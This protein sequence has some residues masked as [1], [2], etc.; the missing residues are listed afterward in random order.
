MGKMASGRIG[1]RGWK[2]VRNGKK[3][4]KVWRGGEVDQTKVSLELNS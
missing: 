2:Q 3:W 1:Q 4:E